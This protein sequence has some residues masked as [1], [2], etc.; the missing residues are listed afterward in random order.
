MSNDHPEAMHGHMVY[1]WEVYYYEM[2]EFN[3]DRGI[4]GRP[5]KVVAVHPELRAEF[6]ISA[7]TLQ[8]AEDA[9]T[10]E[11]LRRR[12]CRVLSLN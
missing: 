1:G 4:D 8:E 9:V 10:G 6:E 11:I 7:D 5:W 2:T 3:L 12:A